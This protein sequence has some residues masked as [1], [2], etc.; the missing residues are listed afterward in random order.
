MLF[1]L[2]LLRKGVN[3]SA[4]ITTTMVTGTKHFFLLHSDIFLP[5]IEQNI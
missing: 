5:I 2:Q 1:S 4:L 3:P